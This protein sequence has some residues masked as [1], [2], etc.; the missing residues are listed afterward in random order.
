VLLFVADAGPGV[1]PHL[2]DRIFDPFF[3]TKEPGQGC[4]L[5]LAIVA[6]LVHAAGGLVWVDPAREG[7]AVF[8]A[9]LPAVE[10]ARCES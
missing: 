10:V 8:K 3:T 5:G 6:Q 7:G 9:F 2:R 4:G 1:P